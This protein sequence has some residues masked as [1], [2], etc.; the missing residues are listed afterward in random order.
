MRVA[1]LVLSSVPYAVLGVLLLLMFQ[2]DGWDGVGYLL[3]VL[4]SIPVLLILSVISVVLAF[5]KAQN[6]RFDGVSKVLS[7]IS[8]ALFGMG[9]LGVLLM[10]ILSM[11]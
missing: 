10:V 7:V 3:V 5:K 1:S 4:A 8:A 6:L 9:T 2:A 11:T